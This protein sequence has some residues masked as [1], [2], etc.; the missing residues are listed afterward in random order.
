MPPQARKP[1]SLPFASRRPP[2]A[3]GLRRPVALPAKA[4]RLLA[5]GRA[6]TENPLQKGLISETMQLTAEWGPPA[7][8]RLFR[9]PVYDSVCSARS[10]TRSWVP[11]RRSS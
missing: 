9:L 5:S 1:F 8:D 4:T 7:V 6:K 11:G 2:L 10:A 3:G